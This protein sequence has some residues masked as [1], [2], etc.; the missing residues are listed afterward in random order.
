[1]PFEFWPELSPA[2]QEVF[3]IAYGTAL[4][5]ALLCILPHARRFFL[6]DRWGGYAESTLDVRCVQNPLC[7]VLI[8]TC[9]MSCAVALMVGSYPVLASFCNVLFCRYFFVHMRWK[10]LLRGMGAPGFLTYWLG[11]VIF[12][13]EYTTYYAPHLQSLALLVLQVDYAFIWLSA[14]IYKI[15]AGYPRNVG[16]ELGMA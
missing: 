3:R 6:A 4:L 13:L 10:G 8:L 11:G 15:T 9:W 14:G 1:M 7:L 12:L 16:M 2:V 5:G